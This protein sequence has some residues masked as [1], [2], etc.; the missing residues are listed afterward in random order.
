MEIKAK[1][2]VNG[3]VTGY[4]VKMEKDEASLFEIDDNRGFGFRC[5]PYG[6]YEVRKEKD[7]TVASVRVNFSNDI[8][9]ED[10][11]GDGFFDTMTDGRQLIGS[12]SFIFFEG[13]FVAV[14]SGK[15]G[16]GETAVSSNRQTAYVFK[17]GSWL[18]DEKISRSQRASEAILQRNEP[19]E[20]IDTRWVYGSHRGFGEWKW[21]EPEPKELAEL[22]SEWAKAMSSLELATNP[23]VVPYL[24]LIRPQ[25]ESAFTSF[26]HERLSSE[27]MIDTM[28]WMEMFF[29]PGA[30]PYGN[31]IAVVVPERWRIG[32]QGLRR[33]S[34]PLASLEDRLNNVETDTRDYDEW[35]GRMEQARK[36]SPLL[37]LARP[38]KYYLA[39]EGGLSLLWY[40]YETPEFDFQIIESS[41]AVLARFRPHDAFDIQRGIS[42]KDAA[43]MLRSLLKPPYSKT[44][45]FRLPSVLKT[46]QVFSCRTDNSYAAFL[47]HKFQPPD[48]TDDIVGFASDRHICLILRKCE[49]VEGTPTPYHSHWS[50]PHP[51]WLRKDLYESNGSTLVIDHRKRMDASA[52]AAAQTPRP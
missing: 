38:M 47:E 30:N 12:K 43:K 52:P 17:D 19:I 33:P 20:T 49:I 28:A 37:P 35:H 34:V 14:S 44:L 45:V 50:E 46:G 8:W 36:A 41:A 26:K 22:T 15:S 13:R 24:N 25:P 51:D 1:R 21:P 5:H 7:G 2:Y 10:M 42:E 31:L 48:W 11:N 6:G 3:N 9:Y 39:P 23:E 27:L 16:I 4:T 32:Q 29:Q 40:Q 18:I